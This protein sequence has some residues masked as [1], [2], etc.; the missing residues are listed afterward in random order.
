[1]ERAKNRAKSKV[2][3]KVEHPIGVIQ[4]GVRFRRGALSRPQKEHPLAARDLRA[5]QSVHGAPAS[6]ALLRRVICRTWPPTGCI[7]RRCYAKNDTATPYFRWPLQSQCRSPS[8]Q[9]LVQTF[10][11]VRSSSSRS[12]RNSL[13]YSCTCLS[14][15]E[16]HCESQTLPSQARVAARPILSSV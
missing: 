9:L 10:L 13:M 7:R 1:M 14:I 6:I 11:R 16:H 3:A 15:S 2:S 5:R 8:R 12:P 4:A